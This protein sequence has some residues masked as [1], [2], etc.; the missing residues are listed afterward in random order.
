[1]PRSY[2][3]TQGSASPSSTRQEGAWLN[4]KVGDQWVFDRFNRFRLEIDEQPATI[5][6]RARDRGQGYL[7]F[8]RR[9]ARQRWL[10][11]SA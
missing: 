2:R 1:M 8:L 9:D 10:I 11:H 3:K 7:P 5:W 4:R 6:P